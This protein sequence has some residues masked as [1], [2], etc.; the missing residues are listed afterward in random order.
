MEG[1]NIL[2]LSLK[3]V[4]VYNKTQFNQPKVFDLQIRAFVK[5]IFYPR[6]GTRKYFEMLP[7]Y[8][9]NVIQSSLNEH[10]A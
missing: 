1:R 9:L 6:E 7:F 3:N 2:N 4:I 8:V 10:F 5:A